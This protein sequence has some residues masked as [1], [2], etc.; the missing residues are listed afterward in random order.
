MTAVLQRPPLLMASLSWQQVRRNP[1]TI[2]YL[3][4]IWVTGLATR[5][6][7]D[8]PP[9]WVSGHVG[10]G[11]PS[12]GQG[13]WWTPLSAG[14][15]A[16]G[17]G[18][19]VAIT[20]LCL[21]IVA[22]AERRMGATRTFITLLISQAAGQFM[23]AGLIKLAGLAGDPWLGALTGQ[24]AV[25]ALPGVLGV[26]FALSCTL[27]LLWRRRLRLALTAA[28]AISAL[29]I[30]HL[31]QIT[32]ACG[33]LAGLATGALTYGRA[34][35]GERLRSSQHEVRLLVAILVAVPALGAM[36]A[37]L[38][39]RPDGPMSLY[40]RWPRAG[41]HLAVALLLLLSAE[42]LRRGCRLAWWFALDINVA[43]LG[44]SVWITYA[45]EA[46]HGV[47]AAH[48]AGLH[49]WPWRILMPGHELLLPAGTVIVL[50]ATRRFLYTP[51]QRDTAAADRARAILTRGG[52]TLSYM[53]TWPARA[54]ASAAR[55]PTGCP[56]LPTR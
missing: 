34:Q 7:A 26:G 39:T 18:S 28:V 2:C 13:Y 5:S 44:L 21:L 41:V 49:A 45:I 53:S 47:R 40:A 32:Q 48:A 9:R 25:G 38:A 23:A 22:P 54:R 6:I 27:S 11:L 14:M 19:Y 56:R 10:A 15:W 52:S 4:A 12:L 36:F 43:V 51:A 55:A 24:T 31:A 37:A 17:L 8:G 46:G 33:A 1:A 29:Y 30:G 16:S 42:G 20:V 35:P 50:L 3:A